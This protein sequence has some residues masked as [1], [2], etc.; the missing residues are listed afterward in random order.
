MEQRKDIVQNENKISHNN[1]WLIMQSEGEDYNINHNR[2]SQTRRRAV[3]E[4]KI[5][6][7]GFQCLDEKKWMKKRKNK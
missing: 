1:I 4:I 6:V 5:L 3:R 7:Y 2:A